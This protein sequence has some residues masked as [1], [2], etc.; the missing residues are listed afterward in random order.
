MMNQD[1]NLG[2][3]GRKR[4]SVKHKIAAVWILLFMEDSKL[5][6]KPS[7][8]QKKEHIAFQN[9]FLDFDYVGSCVPPKHCTTVFMH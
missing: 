4:L 1:L 8:L 7:G 5:L 6:G 2:F 3:Y 9:I